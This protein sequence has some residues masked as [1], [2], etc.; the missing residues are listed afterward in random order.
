[1]FF[2]GSLLY[3]LFSKQNVTSLSSSAYRNLG[4]AV[5]EIA[6]SKGRGKVCRI[7]IRDQFGMS[8]PYERLLKMNGITAEDIAAAAMRL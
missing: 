5:S 7:G 2:V 6:A 8:A 1:M 3:D 4:S